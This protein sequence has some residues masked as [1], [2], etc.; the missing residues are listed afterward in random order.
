M[1]VKKMWRERFA[2]YVPAQQA[3]DDLVTKKGKEGAVYSEAR[4]FLEANP[5]CP[6]SVNLLAENYIRWMNKHNS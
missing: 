5:T 6:Y 3:Y 2:A 1:I 4:N